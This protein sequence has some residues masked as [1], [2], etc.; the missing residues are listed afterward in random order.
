M[1]TK[2][3]F[4]K[5]NKLETGRQKNTSVQL[6]LSRT[7]RF[8]ND[9]PSV[10]CSNFSLAPEAQI[11]RPVA[12][13]RR[14]LNSETCCP[15][16]APMACLFCLFLRLS[17]CLFSTSISINSSFFTIL[18]QRCTPALLV[19]SIIYNGP[20]TVNV[21]KQSAI[22]RQVCDTAVHCTCNSRCFYHWDI[23]YGILP[24]IY[25]LWYSNSLGIFV[26]NLFTVQY[27]T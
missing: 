23:H 4:D 22:A 10:C 18:M 17:G 21:L 19:D 6:Y 1:R 14:V 26:A 25:L 5:H 7:A 15:S 9:V 13:R 3:Q 2:V 20:C 12:I 8:G 11:F 27:C 16:F 24:L